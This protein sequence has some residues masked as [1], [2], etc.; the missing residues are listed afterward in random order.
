MAA[1]KRFFRCEQAEDVGLGDASAAGDLLGRAAL[2]PVGGELGHGSVEHGFASL[3]RR[4]PDRGRGHLPASVLLARRMRSL[5]AARLGGT[6]VRLWRLCAG[7]R[8]ELE[9]VGRDE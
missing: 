7:P 6:L 4:Q 5:R 8:H 1:L 9:V 3:R 2:L